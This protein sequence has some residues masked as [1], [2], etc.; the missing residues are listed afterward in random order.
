MS[1]QGDNFA[2]RHRARRAA[3]LADLL[4][5]HWD[6]LSWDGSTDHPSLPDAAAALS[7]QAWANA[8]AELTKRTGKSFH[9]PSDITRQIVIGLLS[10]PEMKALR[11]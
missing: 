11:F 6:T 3:L 10:M 9:P 7:D 1:E 4:R 5:E 2:M 8:A